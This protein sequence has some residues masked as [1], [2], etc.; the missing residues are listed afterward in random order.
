MLAERL[1]AR[2]DELE[3][4][5]YTLISGGLSGGFAAPASSRAI[6]VMR[7]IGV[8]ISN[9]LSQTI[10]PEM[11]E[12]SDRVMVMT[13]EQMGTILRLVPTAK[14]RVMLLD[15]KG[16]AVE[17]PHGGDLETYRRCAFVIRRALERRVKDL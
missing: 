3:E 5:G 7:E 10:T 16:R 14:G 6:Q 8:D 17:D 11:V 9:H 4:H 15:P 1:K 12:H 2:P 13:P